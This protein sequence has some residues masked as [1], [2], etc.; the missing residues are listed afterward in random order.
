MSALST[1][2]RQYQWL[3]VTCSRALQRSVW[4][5][6][7]SCLYPGVYF[8]HLA[9]EVH[10]PSDIQIMTWQQY[11]VLLP[12][13]GFATAHEDR[14]RDNQILVG[15]NW[16]DRWVITEYLWI[17]QYYQ[18]CCKCSNCTKQHPS[19]QDNNRSASQG[20]SGWNPKVHCHVQRNLQQS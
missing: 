18:D 5:S 6:K 19:W 3:T 10:I 1:V 20:I 4:T 17:P 12:T 7:C 8:E 2:Y 16:V 9:L 15:L 14:V 13:P 11:C